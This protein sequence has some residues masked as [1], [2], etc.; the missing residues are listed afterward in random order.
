MLKY[1]FC[2][3]EVQIILEPLMYALYKTIPM[4]QEEALKLKL[5]LGALCVCVCHTSSQASECWNNIVQQYTSVIAV[6]NKLTS[7]L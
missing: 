5:R 1:S 7:K 2:R 6:K 3:R 4:R